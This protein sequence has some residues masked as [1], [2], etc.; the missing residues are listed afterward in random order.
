MTPR[1]EFMPTI[2]DK[3]SFLEH[4][5]RDSLQWMFVGAVTWHANEQSEH[6]P[7]QR[8]LGMHM[9]FVQARALYDFF[10]G[11][12][13]K[14]DAG[15]SHF[16]VQSDWRPKETKFYADYMANKKPANKRVFHLVYKREIHAGGPGHDDPAH[17]KNQVL[18]FAQ[19]LLS[20]T[21]T[22]I[23][24]T[25]PRFRMLAQSALNNAIAEA[26]SVAQSYGIPSPF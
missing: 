3:K 21:E 7:H 12:I 10:Y 26:R 8:A 5:L 19:D 17:L 25:E 14:D 9:N 4:D 15:A 6:C 16:T 13:T 2:E 23:A 18:N 1:V 20:L 11:D 24:C 22:F